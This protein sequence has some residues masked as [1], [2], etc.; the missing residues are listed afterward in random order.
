MS[1][2]EW[3]SR[4]RKDR[5]INP[6]IPE[7]AYGDIFDPAVAEAL[8]KLCW[9]LSK[10]HKGC[11]VT[12]YG[13][14]AECWG[15]EIA[16]PVFGPRHAD[17]NQFVPVY[18]RQTGAVTLNGT[19]W[20]PD[21]RSCQGECVEVKDTDG[22]AA[23]RNITVKTVAELLP[24]GNPRLQTI[25]GA[26]TVTLDTNYACAVFRSD[27]QN[28]FTVAGK[29]SPV[30]APANIVTAPS[31]LGGAGRVVRADA[32]LRTVEDSDFTVTD[33][34]TNIFSTVSG[35]RMDIPRTV[36]LTVADAASALDFGIDETKGPWAKHY[37]KAM[38]SSGGGAGQTLFDVPTESN[39]AGQVEIKINLVSEGGAATS[40][41]IHAGIAFYNAAGTVTAGTQFTVNNED[42]GLGGAVTLA[43]SGANVRVSFNDG[44]NTARVRAIIVRTHGNTEEP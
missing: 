8:R 42:F 23:T 34:G 21:A 29:G 12:Q 28:W 27:G 19:V 41:I 5:D 16:K 15:P 18:T 11:H 30:G 22:F 20:L 38:T 7:G 25:D 6:A 32:D 31:T 13:M 2:G 44:G 43:A 1:A 40:T 36:A 26:M 4:F 14:R 10:L 37:C 24:T 39:S 35:N 33:D 9:E 3:H 17:P